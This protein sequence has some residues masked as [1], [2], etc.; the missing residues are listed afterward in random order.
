M[1]YCLIGI[2]YSC[3]S[4]SNS[5]SCVRNWVDIQ[6]KLEF[7]RALNTTLNAASLK[8]WSLSASKSWFD[9]CY[10]WRFKKDQA[11]NR[12]ITWKYNS[13]IISL[14]KDVY[15]IMLN[16]CGLASILARFGAN[17]RWEQWSSPEMVQMGSENKQQPV[18][19][20]PS[21][22]LWL[23]I[24]LSQRTRK[25][26]LSFGVLSRSGWFSR[27]LRWN[28][29]SIFRMAEQCVALSEPIL[30]GNYRDH[31]GGT[32]FGQQGGFCSFGNPISWFI[33]PIFFAPSEQ[34]QDGFEL[35]IYSEKMQ[36]WQ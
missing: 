5:S 4:V 6:G 13:E 14:F 22:V 27:H 8:V 28:G 25:Q 36:A 35:N 1:S 17:W 2:Q 24:I 10:H 7:D 15:G 21:H 33:P 16:T 32:L 31:G 34:I 30:G 19:Q 3:I 9:R 11:Y 18:V 12:E 29:K 26:K 23:R 20:M